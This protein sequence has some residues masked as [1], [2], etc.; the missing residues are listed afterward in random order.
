M[1]MMIK[2]PIL[3]CAE[4][5]EAWFNNSLRETFPLSVETRW[6]FYPVV[7]GPRRI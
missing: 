1:M 3:E 5:P 2:L 7:F 6:S 4:K